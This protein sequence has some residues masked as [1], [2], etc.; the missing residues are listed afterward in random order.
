MDQLTANEMMLVSHLG[1]S[2][3]REG[4]YGKAIALFE[5][6]RELDPDY[7]QTHSALAV[8]YHLTE[9]K[10]EALQEAIAALKANPQD[11]PLLLTLGEIYLSLGQ[12]ANARDILNRAYLEAQRIDHPAA[13]RILLLL[14]SNP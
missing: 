11:V 9:R 3:Y 6:L 2:L 13:A 1:Y 10:E 7:P 14:H 5:G 4:Q 12:A 8:L